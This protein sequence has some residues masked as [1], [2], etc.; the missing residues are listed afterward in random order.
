MNPRILLLTVFALFCMLG[1]NAQSNITRV[2]EAPVAG[3][4]TVVIE[5][6][7]RLQK[8]LMGETLVKRIDSSATSHSIKTTTS[9]SEASTSSAR[10]TS[11]THPTSTH[12]VVSQNDHETP[13]QTPPT[14]NLRKQSGGYR[15]QIYSGPA[16]RDAKRQAAIAAGKARFYFPELAAYPIFVSPRWVVVV[17]DFTNREVANEMREHIKKSGAFQEV[18]IV[19]SQI[20]VA[21]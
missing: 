10:S 18:S 7:A 6:D 21:Q 17:G 14:G 5:Q 12:S 3:Q 16:T 1:V 11:L 13:I 4:G 9:S 15:I 8:R 19:R 2:L 20:L